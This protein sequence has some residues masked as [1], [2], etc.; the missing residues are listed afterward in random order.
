MLIGMSGYAQSGK[1]SCAEFMI[2]NYGFER[3]AFADKL[4]LALVHLNPMV[5][6]VSPRSGKVEWFR[7]TDAI[8]YYGGLESLKQ[9]SPETRVL[10]QRLGTEV[11]REIFGNDFWV[12]QAL[13]EVFNLKRIVVTDVRFPNEVAAVRARGG[14]VWRV[15]R[16]G[17][18]PV[19]A[20][21]SETAIDD[22][23]FDRYI[24]NSGTLE[25]LYSQLASVMLGMSVGVV[26][27]V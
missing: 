18:K 7:L 11:G 14:Q 26:V 23:E 17:V 10:L 1:D 13:G 20:H 24:E 27:S 6:Y 25:D 12:N 8:R 4:K 3:R 9:N 5:D 22:V 16:P 21:A 15:V 2:E 19:N